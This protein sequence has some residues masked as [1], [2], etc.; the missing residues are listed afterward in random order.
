MGCDLGLEVAVVAA[1]TRADPDNRAMALDDRWLGEH[2]GD[3]VA[4]ATDA[5]LVEHRLEMI[6]N[7]VL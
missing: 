7:G 3:E 2:R 1:A 4:A 5:D 6:L